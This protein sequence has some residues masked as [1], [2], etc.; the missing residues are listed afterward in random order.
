MIYFDEMSMLSGEKYKLNDDV[1]LCHPTIGDIRK[2]KEEPYFSNL[3]VLIGTPSQ[4]KFQLADIGVDYALISDYEFFLMAYKE[5]SDEV[6]QLFFDG[7]YLSQFEPYVNRQNEIVLY[8]PEYKY[9]IDELEYI[10]MSEYFRVI[11]SR[12][13]VVEK[14]GNQKTKKYLIDRDRKRYER[15][16]NKPPKSIMRPLISAMVNNNHFKYNYETI[17]DVCI[18]AFYES[19]RQIQHNVNHH[20]LMTGI[21]TG[22]IDIKKISQEELSFIDLETN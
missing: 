18:Y 4:C 7:I 16:K 1:F 21:Y 2:I 11:H 10:R 3:N 13:K 6:S 22:N 5:L 19:I 17:E 8:H 20:H 9:K 15:A 14:Y 12:E